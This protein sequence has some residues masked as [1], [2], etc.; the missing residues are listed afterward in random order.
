MTKTRKIADSAIKPGAITPLDKHYLAL[1]K[2][3]RLEPIRSDAQLKRAS[4][5][6]S[7]LVFNIADLSPGKLVY[8]DALKILIGEYES[9]RY[10][11]IKATP[12]EL[13]KLLMEEQGL[14]QADLV[15]DFGGKGYVSE[16][17]SGKRP[18]SK[19][20]TARLCKRFSLRPEALLPEFQR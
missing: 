16:F 17:L 7:D 6:L 2:T 14:K 5:I 12:A 19:E 18:L 11:P 20:V 15:S 4:A 3:F 13:L 9:I 8:K 10:K 1:I